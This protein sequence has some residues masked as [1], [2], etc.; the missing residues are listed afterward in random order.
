MLF[1]IERRDKFE[2]EKSNS[3]NNKIGF[4]MEV[5]AFSLFNPLTQ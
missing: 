1:G 2:M 4:V 5:M 3:N